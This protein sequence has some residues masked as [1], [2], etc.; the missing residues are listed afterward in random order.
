MKQG[1]TA[2]EISEW[3][4]RLAIEREQ[5]DTFFFNTSSVADTS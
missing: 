2:M 1:E 5:K 4:E 3:E